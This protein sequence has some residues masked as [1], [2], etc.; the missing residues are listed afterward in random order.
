MFNLQK[1]RLPYRDDTAFGL[2]AFCIFVV[3]LAFSLFS[4]ENFESVKFSLFLIFSGAAAGLFF[5]KQRKTLAIKSQKYFF[6]LL[7][8]FGIWSFISALLATDRLY[9][10]LG[11]YYRYTSG[12]LFYLVLGLFIWLLI[13]ILDED[14]LEFLLKILLID[15]LAVSVVAYLQ[16]FGWIFYAGLILGGFYRGP[17]LLGNSNFSAMFLAAG[18]PFIIYFFY[19]SQGL[20][21]KIYYA[22]V[23]FMVIFAEFLLASRGA[24]LAMFA[25]LGSALVLLAVYK[26][27]K[28]YLWTL[29]VSAAIITILGSFFLSVSRPNAVSS[30][31]IT[32]DS[33]TI[34][35]FYSWDVS[36]KEIKLH[37]WFGAGP[38]NFALFFERSRATEMPG[39]AGIFDDAHNLFIQLAATGGIPLA[40]L[41]VFILLL[42][43]YYGLKQLKQSQKPIVLALI[44]SLAAWAVAACFN[45]VPVPMF[46]LLAIILAGLFFSSLNERLISFG[47]VK[48]VAAVLC[49][50]VILLLGVDS[51]ASEHF[52]GL[53]KSAYFNN[54][55]QQAYALAG[56]A[57]QINP[58]NGLYLI[59]KIGSEIALKQPTAQIQADMAKFLNL[60]PTQANTY[61]VASNL[62]AQA[63]ANSKDK[64]DLNAA[65][66][67]MEK[68]VAIDPFFSDRYGQL[69]LYYY[70]LGNFT[71]AKI[72]AEKNLALDSSNFSAWILLAR[73]YQLQG[74]KRAYG[75]KCPKRQAAF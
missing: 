7:G 36:F 18:S 50:V 67:E 43:G 6:W 10:F 49:A 58:T 64:A 41:F 42:A 14:K 52:L 16:S 32:V 73:L 28:K 66:S 71:Q 60:H 20:A 30:A 24:L 17:S 61:V 21:A 2:L 53:A 40:L 69:A 65:V 38:G 31:I 37:P 22:F 25:A 75:Q 63:F 45:P 51:L 72:D 62:Y 15:A 39:N 70:Q 26:F 44:S 33:N 35:R 46:L 1:L 4:Y 47:P 11:F 3:P 29:L 48:K 9:S 59:F 27:P 8:F 34:T 54:D 56:R 23:G 55:Y 5:L 74:Q 19:K 12:M 68:A 57:W 13:N